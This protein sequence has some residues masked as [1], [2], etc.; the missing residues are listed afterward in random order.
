MQEM[1]AILEHAGIACRD[2]FRNRTAVI[3]LAVAP[4]ETYAGSA[5]CIAIGQRLFLAT[6][7][8][9]FRGIE[10]LGARLTV[11]S[12][13]RSSDTPI[14][15][16]RGN[17]RQDIPLGAPD[18]AWLEVDPNSAAACNLTGV[19]VNA[20]DAYPA[21]NERDLY[22]MTGFPSGLVQQVRDRPNHINYVVPMLVY[23][24]H[25]VNIDQ[26]PG[27]HI[28]FS[29]ERNGIG[30]VGRPGELPIPRGMSGGGIWHVPL[31]EDPAD[32]VWNPGRM[33]LG[34]ITLEYFEG[35][36]EA[37]GLPLREWL[38]VLSE[39]LPELL[40]TVKTVLQR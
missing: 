35:R 28:V 32:E 36:R 31:R 6:A 34:G 1:A 16:L 14:A 30:P 29:F 23:F 25:A 26:L 33:R 20:L 22:A 27:D 18:V 11:F 40:P 3:Y 15:I 12:A 13:N 10:K 17:Y 8:H 9:N 21:L 4:D 38:R 2:Y 37:T 24:T 5:T 7:A 19:T 39:D